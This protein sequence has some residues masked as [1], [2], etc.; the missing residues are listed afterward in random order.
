MWLGATPGEDE[1][2]VFPG[3]EP[4]GKWT[5]KWTPKQ[6]R[7]PRL[8]FY[9]PRLSK[10]RQ[11]KYFVNFSP[12]ISS[13][14]KKEVYASIREWKLQRKTGSTIYHLAAHVNPVVRGW[15]GYYGAFFQSELLFLVRHLDWKLCRWVMRKYKRRGAGYKKAMS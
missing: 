13:K 14:A 5:G 7:L 6:L 8:L 10:N 4:T 12:A 15:I 2:C 3:C 1:N 11:G 9:R